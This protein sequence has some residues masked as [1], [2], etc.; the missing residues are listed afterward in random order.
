M[1]IQSPLP[2]NAYL[3]A[4]KSQMGGHFEFGVERYTGFFLG[5][6]FYVTH[7]TGYDWEQRY[8]NL[9]NAAM[10]YV[11]KKENGCEVHFCRFRGLLCPLHFL[12]VWL[13]MGLV[14]SFGPLF[15]TQGDIK[16]LTFFWILA[17]AA[18]LL[19]ALISVPFEGLTYAGEEGRRCL[20]S[21]L[22]DPTDP[23]ANI[24]NVP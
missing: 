6:C 20:L 15:E 10:G 12:T 2:K 8:T 18:T 3:A 22:L 21:I 11:I 9:K 1:V 24:K 13:I 4:M 14:G 16:T 23:Y 17:F 7:H 19:A 5:N